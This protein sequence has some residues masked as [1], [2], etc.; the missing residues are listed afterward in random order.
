MDQLPLQ[1]Q[2][3]KTV[4]RETR[5]TLTEAYLDEGPFRLQEQEDNTHHL[6]TRKGVQVPRHNYWLQKPNKQT[7]NADGW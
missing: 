6:V 1:P 4:S 7:L 3:P 2:L 5:K